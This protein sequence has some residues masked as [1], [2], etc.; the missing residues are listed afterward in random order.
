[1]SYAE[2]L[3]I[4]T[5]ERLTF[6]YPGHWPDQ[7]E[8]KFLKSFED[9]KEL[10]RAVKAYKHLNPDYSGFHIKSDFQVIS[11]LLVDTRCQCWTHKE[12]DLVLWNDRNSNETVRIAVAT[13]IFDDYPIQSLNH[14]QYKIIHKDVNY[15]P[16]VNYKK[17]VCAFEKSGRVPSSLVIMKKTIFKYEKEHR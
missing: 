3:D 5:H 10:D 7:L 8:M 12:D 6:K 1:M 11:S 2:F 9:I 15:V 14:R 4:F 16:R 17:L 13:N